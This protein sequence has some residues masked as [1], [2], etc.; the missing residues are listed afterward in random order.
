MINGYW[1]TFSIAAAA[2]LGVADRLAAGPA[3]IDD[4]ARSC[5]A[6]PESLYRL[7]RALASVGI[8]REEEGRR[9]ANTPLSEALR[10]DVPGSMR[11]LAQMTLM[12]HLRAWPE[13][14]HAV[15]T[16]ETAFSKVFGAELFDYLGTHSEAARVFDSAFSGYTAM[17]SNAVAAAYDFSRF[18]R[19]V[20]VG[21]GGGA[22]LAAVLARVPGARGV[23]FDL[24]HVAARARET[25]QKA[26][27][28]DRGETVGGDFFQAVP[29]GGDAYLLK[30]ILHDWDDARA[31]AILANVRKAIRPGGSL[32]VVEVVVDGPNEG[33]PAKLL[34][35]NMLV[36]TGGRERT[37]AEYAELFRAAG[38]ELVGVAAAGPTNVI[39]GR[40]IG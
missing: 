10:S 25:L 40:P 33:A 30:M 14:E 31:I 3:A 37:R 27:V 23:T 17:V 9:F 16:G 28:A 22:L 13:V 12:L 39:E 8:F 5:E 15:R 7:L 26:G 35:V 19:V 4:L 21:G 34:D 11:G 1:T 20:D 2:K 36:M 24:P 38:F 18:T 6:H 29:E 32:L